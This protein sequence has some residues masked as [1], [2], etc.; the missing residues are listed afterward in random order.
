MATAR[1]NYDCHNQI[2]RW[3]YLPKRLEAVEQR[4]DALDGWRDWAEGKVITDGNVIDIVHSLGA[5]ARTDDRGAVVALA[6]VMHR[7][8]QTKG[9]DLSRPTPTIERAGIEIDF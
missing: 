9:L 6:D 7:W 2:E 4:I 5:A 8:A 1:R 3:S